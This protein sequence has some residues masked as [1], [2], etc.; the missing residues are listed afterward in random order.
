MHSVDVDLCEQGCG[1]GNN[2][3]YEYILCLA[4]LTNIASFDEPCDVVAH[5]RPPIAECDKSKGSEVP[6]M[7]G[8]VVSG[9]DYEDSAVWGD[10]DLVFPFAIFTPELFGDYEELSTV[11][12]EHLIV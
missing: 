1:S 11:T 12:Q 9:S 5:E 7:S 6:V 4:P 10:E 2:R 8:V 3:R